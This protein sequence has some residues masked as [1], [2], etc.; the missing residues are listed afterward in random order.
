MEEKEKNSVKT[1]IEACELLPEPQRQRVLGIAEGIAIANGVAD[2]DLGTGTTNGRGGNIFSFG[3]VILHGGTVIGG[4]ATNGSGY[5]GNICITGKAQGLHI[6]GDAQVI[7]GEAKTG[8]NIYGMY[9]KV[10]INGGVIADGKAGSDA[11]GHNICT[12]GTNTSGNSSVE[13]TSPVSMLW[14]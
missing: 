14:E 9:A 13:I 7:G 11:N 6:D 4:K 10:V 12:S 1:L 8:G 2:N 3:K 5:G